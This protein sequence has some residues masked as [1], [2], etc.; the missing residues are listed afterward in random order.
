IV[1][2]TEANTMLGRIMLLV[3]LILAAIAAPGL[4][5]APKAADR[6]VDDALDLPAM[7]PTTD[8][9]AAEGLKGF[10]SVAVGGVTSS[11]RV[12]LGD[13]AFDSVAGYSHHTQAAGG[14]LVFR[15]DQAGW[16]RQYRL[17]LANPVPGDPSHISRSVALEVAEYAD[18][19]GADDALTLLT[20]I[21]D[22]GDA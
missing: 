4:G 22:L 17:V 14:E 8:D 10:A 21:G 11:G 19:D 16:R 20:T 5:T 3:W 12:S 15:L 18:A 7:V 9:L 6:P 1:V 13:V 2:A